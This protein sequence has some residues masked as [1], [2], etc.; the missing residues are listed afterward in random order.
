MLRLHELTK[1]EQHSKTV[2]ITNHLPFFLQ[3]PCEVQAT[4]H[5]EAIEDYHVVQLR[6]TGDL[7]VICQRCAHEFNLNYDNATAIAVCKTDARAEQL[8]E[9]MECIVSADGLIELEDLIRDDLHLYAPQSHPDSNDCDK[10][11][12]QIVT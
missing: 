2:A 1:Q 9:T 10:E 4:Y 11:V 12:M 6:V 7:T 8:Q 5:V 3:G